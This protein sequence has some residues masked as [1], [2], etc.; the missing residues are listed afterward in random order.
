MHDLKMIRKNPKWFDRELKKRNLPAMSSKINKLYDEYTLLLKNAEKNQSERNKKSKEIAFLNKNNKIKAEKIK[1][2][3]ISLKGSV[4]DLTEKYKVKFNEI[5]KILEVIPNF[6]DEKTPIG[7]SENDNVILKKVGEK[8]NFDFKIR[9][10]VQILEDLDFID[11]EK[12]VK[13]SGSRFS[14]LKDELALLNRALINYMLDLHTRINGYKEV[15]VPELVK[16]SALYGTGQLP[17]FKD[18]LFKTTGDLW[19]IPTAEVCLT[20]LHREEIMN[21]NQLPLRYTTFTNCFR[22]EA[23]SAG[24]DTKG[25]IREHQFGKVELVSITHP[26]DS[27]IEIERMTE[28]VEKILNDLNLPFQKIKLC[29]AD[30]GFSSSYTIDFEVWMPGQ[31]KYREVSSCSNCKEFQSRRMKMRAR[32]K[33]NNEIYFP[34][35]LNGSGLAIGRIIVAIIENHQRSD[36][37]ISIPK[38]LQSYMN[39]MKEIK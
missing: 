8:K 9:N 37:S 33:S 27:D 39:G 22:S 24:V 18:D 15:I 16:Y 35:T 29:S 28:C 1:N 31:K 4:L 20:N 21:E 26:S 34:H 11:Y 19:L 6:L 3:V 2:E 13:L 25:L 10:H 32:N 12:A 5:L 23:G 7:N 30:L 14:V 36:G 17:K 38:V